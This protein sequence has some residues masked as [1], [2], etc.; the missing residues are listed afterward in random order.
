MYIYIVVHVFIP[1]PPPPPCTGPFWYKCTRLQKY[2]QKAYRISDGDPLTV[3]E[4]NVMRSC[5]WSSGTRYPDIMVHVFTAQ[6]RS[7]ETG[8]GRDAGNSSKSFFSEQGWVPSIYI[9]IYYIHGTHVF[10][11]VEISS[12]Y[13]C[14]MIA[15]FRK[16]RLFGAS[17]CCT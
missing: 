7:G 5:R 15:T 2:H 14:I 11:I 6:V 17:S 10:D 1:S 13:L 8:R 16:R 3:M 4:K 12:G 9:K